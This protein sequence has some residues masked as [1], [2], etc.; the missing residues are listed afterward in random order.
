MGEEPQWSEDDAPSPLVVCSKEASGQRKYEVGEAAR[1]KL[2]S[3]I[4]NRPVKI[5]TVCG[6]YRSGKS[7]LL[8]LIMGT[9]QGKTFEVG[10]TV[11]ACTAG[12]WLRHSRIEGPNDPVVLLLDCEGSGNTQSDREHDAR[13]VALALLLCTLFVFNSKGVV[14]EGAIQSLSVVTSLAQM[15]LKQHLEEGAG[16]V[17]SAQ[18]PALLWVLRDFALALEDADGKEITP[19]QYLDQALSADVAGPRREDLREA[20]EKLAELF[21]KRDCFP[22]VRPVDEEDQLQRLNELPHTALRPKFLSEVDTLKSKVFSECQTKKGPN[23]ELITGSRFVAILE[24]Y[25]D[26]LNSGKVPA[27]GSTWQ[28]VSN[29]EC[30]QALDDALRH[31]GT[32]VLSISSN[33]P[34]EEEDL[35]EGLTKAEREAREIF[36]KRALGSDDAR[37]SHLDELAKTV[38]EKGSRLRVQNEDTAVRAN[39][40]F[41]RGYWNNAVE[42]KLRPMAHSHASEGGVSAADCEAA[43]KIIQEGFEGL[44]KSYE[45]KAVGPAVARKAPWATIEQR[46]QAALDEVA[47]WEGREKGTSAA[48]EAAVAAE[49]EERRRLKEQGSKMAADVRAEIEESKKRMRERTEAEQKA[50][51]ATKIE[52]VNLTEDSKNQDKVQDL[53]EKEAKP[54]GADAKKKSCCVTM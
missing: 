18:N 3:D 23:G 20:R 28:H 36:E 29:A 10:N 51:N 34:V 24:S 7:F 2:V 49:E 9:N 27:I 43:R 46:R 21:K 25:T 42:A 12:I 50:E 39:E 8:N 13:I 14:N 54:K 52:E 40:G 19:K 6:L 35:E 33:F 4:G 32:K 26:S 22:L 48:K 1:K 47:V 5:V 37:R 16:G 17:L 15:V 38:E 44:R 41:L 45:T 31:F 53:N 11:N 30:Q